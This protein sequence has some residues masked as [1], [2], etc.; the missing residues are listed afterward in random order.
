MTR[1]RLLALR[2]T[3]LVMQLGV[4][5]FLLICGIYFA[6]P[7]T[8]I[9]ALVIAT[10]GYFAYRNA[11][12]HDDDTIADQDQEP[13]PLDWCEACDQLRTSD[14]MRFDILGRY[15][16][17]TCQPRNDLRTG[18]VD[19]YDKTLPILD[20]DDAGAIVHVFGLGLL[21]WN[22]YQYQRLNPAGYVLPSNV[23]PVHIGGRIAALK[24]SDAPAEIHSWQHGRRTR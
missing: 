9:C 24:Y 16:C 15:R 13:E 4:A 3:G 11:T 8:I 2:R 18:H 5:A 17:T 14:Q 22:G 19:G 12:R 21:K 7:I 20:H 23:A 10:V 1:W 6:K